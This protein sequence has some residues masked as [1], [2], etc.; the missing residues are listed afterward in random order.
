MEWLIVRKRAEYINTNASSEFATLGTLLQKFVTEMN[1]T[2]TIHNLV[3][4]K[5]ASKR[6]TETSKRQWLLMFLKQMRP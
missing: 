1:T 6:W 2:A 3:Q 5:S 4:S